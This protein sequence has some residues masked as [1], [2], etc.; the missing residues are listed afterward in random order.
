M[1]VKIPAGF[2]INFLFVY[3]LPQSIDVYD[4][5]YFLGAERGFGYVDYDVDKEPM[6]PTFLKYLELIKKSGHKKGKI[7]D[8]GAATGFFL[9][10]AKL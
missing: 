1:V 10:I 3:P 2:T 4:E 6:V 5:A 8:V 9:K 7:L